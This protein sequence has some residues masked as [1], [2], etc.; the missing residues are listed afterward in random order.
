MHI[1]VKYIFYFMEYI[2]IIATKL[3]HRLIIFSPNALKF[4][5][6]RLKLIAFIYQVTKRLKGLLHNANRM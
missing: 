6:N 5:E 2:I 1:N 3:V 4:D